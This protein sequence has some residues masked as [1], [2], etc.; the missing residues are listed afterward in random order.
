M[1]NYY[2]QLF[3]YYQH[4]YDF[5]LPYKFNLN[6]I[7]NNYQFPFMEYRNHSIDSY[8]ANNSCPSDFAENLDNTKANG[9]R[10]TAKDELDN[11][12]T[13]QTGDTLYSIAQNYGITVED[14]TEIN[15]IKDDKIFP[16]QVLIIPQSELNNTEQTI[17]QYLTQENDTLQKIAEKWDTTLE[18]LLKFNDIKNLI[19]AP[20][21]PVTL[22]YTPITYMINEDDTFERILNDNK[23]TAGDLLRLNPQLLSSGTIIYIK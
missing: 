9:L 2:S 15:S 6:S 10:T 23:L 18:A 5:D 19:L 3:D 14:I 16:N 20:N 13:V 12:Y 7:D 21:T 1:K 22:P 4:P 11:F 8:D 17:I